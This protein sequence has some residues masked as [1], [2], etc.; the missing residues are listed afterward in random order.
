MCPAQRDK[1]HNEI[2]I[3]LGGESVLDILEKEL[4]ALSGNFRS[5]V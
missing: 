1:P 2:E 5:N 3:M 4:V